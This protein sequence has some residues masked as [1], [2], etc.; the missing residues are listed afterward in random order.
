MSINGERV[1]PRSYEDTVSVPPR[2]EVVI[3]SRFLDY[4]GK[5]VFHCHILPHED[6]GMMSL[7]EVVDSGH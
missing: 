4:T 7:V 1:P 3:R 5:Y 6:A 2:S